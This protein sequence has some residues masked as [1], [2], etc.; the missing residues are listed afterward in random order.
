MD[1]IVIGLCIL[2]FLLWLV[3]QY[4]SVMQDV[5]VSGGYAMSEMIVVGG[6]YDIYCRVGM[7][8]DDG[9]KVKRWSRFGDTLRSPPTCEVRIS[10]YLS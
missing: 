1:C 7:H 2:L 4:L 6:Y 3:T 5:F 8:D 10:L 9:Q